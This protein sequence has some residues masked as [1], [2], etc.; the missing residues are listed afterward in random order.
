MKE[1]ICFTLIIFLFACS[2]EN[3]N[4]ITNDIFVTEDTIIEKD[5]I[6]NKIILDSV[7]V[8][9][10][11]IPTENQN[12]NYSHLSLCSNCDLIELFFEPC[13]DEYE[14]DYKINEVNNYYKS[15]KQTSIKILDTAYLK[16]KDSAEITFFYKIQH[17]KN[18]LLRR[19]SIK[20][21]DTTNSDSGSELMGN[22]PNIEDH[23]IH[24][25]CG[26]TIFTTDFH[27]NQNGQLCLI[28]EK[29]EDI[30]TYPGSTPSSSTKLYLIHQGSL[31]KLEGEG[32]PEISSINR[33]NKSPL[34]E[35]SIRLI[36]SKY[37]QKIIDLFF[38]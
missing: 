6:T 36:K 20:K 7:Q 34:N 25:E 19:I 28:E 13:C 1:L 26:T 23:W 10:D 37:P 12:F 38:E 15:L 22:D 11:S 31:I 16:F 29:I 4:I 35:N 17:N 32:Y 3:E 8:V 24:Y 2:N 27:F 21:I 14:Y 30:C 33:R 5:N 9:N 18:K